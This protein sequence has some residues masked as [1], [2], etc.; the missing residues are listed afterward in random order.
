MR[1]VRGTLPN[2]CAVLGPGGAGGFRLTPDTGNAPTPARSF[3]NPKNGSMP[4]RGRLSLS[5]ALVSEPP[6]AGARQPPRA[7]NYACL[8]TP[9]FGSMPTRWFAWSASVFEP[10][11]PCSCLNALAKM[12]NSSAETD[13]KTTFRF[14]RVHSSQR[15]SRR[16]PLDT[17]RGRRCP[18]QRWSSVFFPADACRQ[19]ALASIPAAIPV[20]SMATSAST[21]S[22]SPARG[23]R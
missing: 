16:S 6:K 14:L 1:R 7:R 9:K 8:R 15:R 4:T 22:Q 17:A 20:R 21:D 19:S 2:G 23:W 13:R 12:H 10:Q 5:Y 11:I 18:D 3:Q